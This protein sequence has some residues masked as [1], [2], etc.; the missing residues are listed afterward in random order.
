MSQRKTRTS[1]IVEM[2]DAWRKRWEQAVREVE[3]EKP[4]LEI[5]HRQIVAAKAEPT[6]SGQLRRAAHKNWRSFPEIVK[7]L[8]I[9]SEDYNEFLAGQRPLPSDVMD[10]LAKLLGLELAPVET[11]NADS[12]DETSKQVM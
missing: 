3:A 8:G 12:C 6:L 7:E 10:R 11:G 5:L 1:R 9:S 4:E 2:D